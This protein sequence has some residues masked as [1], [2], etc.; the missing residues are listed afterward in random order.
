MAGY[1][2][3][4][5]AAVRSLTR[6]ARAEARIY[7]GEHPGPH[8][9]DVQGVTLVAGKV[10]DDRAEERHAQTDGWAAIG[11]MVISL[12]ATHRAAG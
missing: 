7:A 9:F 12:A 6:C 11:T 10:P 8:V 1:G 3:D 4:P 5:A 2:A